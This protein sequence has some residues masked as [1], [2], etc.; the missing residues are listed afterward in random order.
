MS[1]KSERDVRIGVHVEYHHD[2]VPHQG[3]RVFTHGRD[4]KVALQMWSSGETSTAYLSEP[5][6]DELINALQRLKAQAQPRS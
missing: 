3:V 1:S 5:Q 2:R 4:S 6:V